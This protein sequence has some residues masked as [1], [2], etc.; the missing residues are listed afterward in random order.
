[1]N[2]ICA[3]LA[4]AAAGILAL[5]VGTTL[6]TGGQPAFAASSHSNENASQRGDNSLDGSGNGSASVASTDP[7]ERGQSSTAPGHTKFESFIQNA[8]IEAKA[9]PLNSAR[10]NLQAFIHANPKSEVGKIAIY[11]KA[12][13][14][15][16]E[17]TAAVGVA[18][19]AF[20]AS[21]VAFKIAYPGYPDYDIQTLLDRQAELSNLAMPTPQE[22]A[23]LIA[24]TAVLST[25]EATNLQAALDELEQ[26]Q[27]AEAAALANAAKKPV[28]GETQAWLD[29]QLETGGILDYYRSQ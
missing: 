13:V 20:D 12:V 9:G 24:L 25:Q 14:A 23:E 26:A 17:A 19:A 3:T 8:A 10:A 21:L 7:E 6:T 18:A 29:A 22:T 28:D 5:P 15:V 4:F 27:L 1:M 11:A 2:R 16:E